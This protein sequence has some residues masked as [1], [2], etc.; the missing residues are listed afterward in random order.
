MYR[1]GAGLVLRSENVPMIL[2][3]QLLALQKRHFFMRTSGRFY[4]GITKTVEPPWLKI[5]YP[6]IDQKMLAALPE[7]I[8]VTSG[9]E[10]K[11]DT[12]VILEQ[13]GHDI[14]LSEGSEG[15]WIQ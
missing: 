15:A 1:F 12:D 7:I 3:Q 8:D 9:K 13:F 2:S 10:M 14:L 11:A 5:E 6:G 4:H